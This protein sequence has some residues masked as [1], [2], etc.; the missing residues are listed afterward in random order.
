MADDLNVDDLETIL[1]ALQEYTEQSGNL[2]NDEQA[3]IKALRDSLVLFGGI[4]TTVNFVPAWLDKKQGIY[5]QASVREARVD[6]TRMGS[7]EFD[8]LFAGQGREEDAHWIQGI[9]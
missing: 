4:V 9:R 8:R 1:F 3:K 7:E 2:T 5:H 6:V